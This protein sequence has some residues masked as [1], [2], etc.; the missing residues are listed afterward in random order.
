[1]GY[2]FHENF[3]TEAPPHICP[4]CA[5]NLAVAA[6]L[7][8]HTENPEIEG[9]VQVLINISR[10]VVVI[11]HIPVAEYGWGELGVTTVC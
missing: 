9:K 1:M 10:R 2:N 8:Y 11:D 6:V 4:T 5:Q 3:L 7:R